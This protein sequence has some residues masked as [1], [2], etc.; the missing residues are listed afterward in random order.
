MEFLFCFAPPPPPPRPL[1]YLAIKDSVFV[2]FFNTC[3]LLFNALSVRGVTTFRVTKLLNACSYK[4]TAFPVKLELT[5]LCY[6]Y[7]LINL[8]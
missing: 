8:S 6:N 3:I 4:L 1:N 2:L 5:F 7:D